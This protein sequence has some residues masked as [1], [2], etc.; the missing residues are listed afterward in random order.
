[1]SY[2]TRFNGVGQMQRYTAQTAQSDPCAAL[3]LT[4][5]SAE[6]AADAYLTAK[7]M[8]GRATVTVRAATVRGCH[9]GFRAIV[10]P[11]GRSPIT[12]TTYD[13]L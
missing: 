10:T 1:M 3:F 2:S 6:R 8:H 5:K 7:R 9:R 13:P 12:L 4:P 11:E